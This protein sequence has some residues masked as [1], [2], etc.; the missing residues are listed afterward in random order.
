MFQLSRLLFVPCKYR[1]M[2]YS[3]RYH[4][5]DVR[6]KEFN[7]LSKFPAEF[8]FKH[9]V[10]G[11]SSMYWAYFC[12]W[13]PKIF[14]IIVDSGG[15][16]AHLESREHTHPE[17]DECWCPSNWPR[18]GSQEGALWPPR[19]LHSERLPQLLPVPAQFI[20]KRTFKTQIHKCGR[21]HFTGEESGAW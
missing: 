4:C 2:L 20:W 9:L 10:I 13:H 3:L 7:V 15:E 5:N 1:Y 21:Q 12:C 11:C 14:I 6:N 8:G 17:S 16:F 18:P 19:I